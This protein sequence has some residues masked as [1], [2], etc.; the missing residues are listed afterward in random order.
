MVQ[1][2][3][4][5]QTEKYHS[6]LFRYFTFICKR[7]RI[8]FSISQMLWKRFCTLSNSCFNKTHHIEH[9]PKQE[10]PRKNNINNSISY[11]CLQSPHHTPNTKPFLSVRNDQPTDRS[12]DKTNN[13][14]NNATINSKHRIICI[15]CI[16][17][18]LE[19]Q[20]AWQTVKDV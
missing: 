17:I 5:F 3:R 4:P 11:F 2:L 15:K 10:A 8:S 19:T 12:T 18:L 7:L 6:I 16:G 20:S 14:N 9:A 1:E 13:N